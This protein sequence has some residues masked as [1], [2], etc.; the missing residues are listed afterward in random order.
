MTDPPTKPVTVAYYYRVKWGHDKEWLDLFVRNHWPLLR[1][2]LRDGS[3]PTY[4]STRRASTAT[5]GLTGT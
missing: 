4:A 1:E 5:D 3:S 2:G